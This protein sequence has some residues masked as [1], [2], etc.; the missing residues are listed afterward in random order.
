VLELE[1]VIRLGQTQ[2]I[3]SESGRSTRSSQVLYTLTFKIKIRGVL[4]TLTLTHII[5]L[6]EIHVG[7][8][9]RNIEIITKKVNYTSSLLSYLIVSI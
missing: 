4:T 8:A 1:H 6:S 3:M 9:P 2:P 7:Y 5:L